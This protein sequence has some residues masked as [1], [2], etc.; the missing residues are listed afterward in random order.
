MTFKRPDDQKGAPH[1]SHVQ[2]LHDT[3]HHVQWYISLLALLCIGHH[4]TALDTLDIG[5]P[6]VKI[7]LEPYSSLYVDHTGDLDIAGLIELNPEFSDDFELNQKSQYPEAYWLHIPVRAYTSWEAR[8]V[9]PGDTLNDYVQNLIDYLDLFI[10]NRKGE[11]LKTERTGFLQARSKKSLQLNPFVIAA[12][13][14]FGPDDDLDL[15]IRLQKVR[16]PLRLGLKL[17][18]RDA[19]SGLPQLDLSGRWSILGP[20]GMFIIIGLY[21]LVFYYFVR[22]RSF[23]YFGIFCLLYAH[24]LICIEPDGGLI[25][26]IPEHPQRRTTLFCLSLY[27]IVFLMLFGDNFINVK[28]HFPLWH[29]YY[30]G[31]IIVIFLV[32]S[33]Y[34]VRSFWKPYTTIH[35]ALPIA[36]TLIIPFCIRFIW[37]KYWPARIFAIGVFSFLGGNILGLITLIIGLDWGPVFW[38]A[39]SIILLF[40]FA[41]GLGYRLLESQRQQA[42]I[43]K[44]KELDLMKSRFFTN[45]SHEFRTPLSLIL[46]PV[47]LSEEN[48]PLNE[49]ENPQ[50]E[51]PIKVS[52]IRAIKRNAL[53]L[54]QLI[55]QIM[56]L[57]KLEAGKLQLHLEQGAIIHFI[58]RRIAEFIDIARQKNIHILTN[59]S[60]ENSDAYFDADKVE[61]ILNNLLANAIKYTPE[62]GQI[63]INAVANATHLTVTIADSGPGLTHEEAI[64][65]FD[66]F[67]QAD[68]AA[69]QGSGVG[70]ALVKELV[71]LH[72]GQISVD[73]QV[74]K[75]VAITLKICITQD[76][77]PKLEFSTG[78]AEI[79]IQENTGAADLL[80]EQVPIEELGM[81]DGQFLILIV[82][83]NVDLQ[84]FIKEILSE[85]FQVIAAGDGNEGKDLALK[86]LPDL[87]LSDIM[88]PGLSG[89]DLCRFLK[90]EEKTSHIPVILLTAKSESKHKVQ[91]LAIGADDFLTKPFDTTELLL[92]VKNAV[93]SRE[94]LR[95]K[96]NKSPWNLSHQKTTSIDEQFLQRTA[97][98]IHENLSNEYY[99]VEALGQGIGYSRSQLFRKLKALTGKSPVELIREQRFHYAKELLEGNSVT[100]AEAAYLV[101]YSNVSYF[102]QTFKKIFGISPSQVNSN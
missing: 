68:H 44:M 45:I 14:S 2:R 21:V 32:V 51:I 22:D 63:I 60:K 74:E 95:K 56:D 66:R 78:S 48:I 62:N 92:K 54:R 55:D 7:D 12:P 10:V 83:D 36:I 27:S 30:Q 101:G 76:L 79:S 91:G 85:E 64:Y 69:Q 47:Q 25:H 17:E 6:T 96:Y 67:Y 1:L 84:L 82:E 94:E 89:Y 102:S 18:L 87:V 71:E 9:I 65:I 97:Q 50:N 11:V 20:W 43:E 100:V 16:Y 77:F 4:A 52:H 39:G 81:A 86:H 80:P 70:L 90:N 19:R 35:P 31:F 93:T 59:Y 58:R 75:G 61:K 34:V 37:S 57:S 41:L 3:Y 40:V 49:M 33:F 98:H 38:M 46:G 99:S 73:S 8:L 5:Q 15:Y 53:R 72:K 29:R 88:M 24:G 23:L 13:I 28:K 26:L 42:S